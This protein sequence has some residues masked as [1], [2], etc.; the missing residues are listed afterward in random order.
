ML[1]EGFLL[2]SRSSIARRLA[3][4]APLARS[5]ARRFV[6]GDTI[7]D[8]VDATRLLNRQG[9]K[10]TIDYLGES[11]HSREEAR[12]AA[13]V[14]IDVLDRISAARLD[15]N[16]S[17]KLTQ[18]GQDI[19]LTF[20]RA[21]VGRILD[22]ARELDIFV[23]FDMESSAYTQRTLDFFR[24]VW[25][26]GYTNVGVVIQS[27]LRRSE[28]DIAML[29]EL[30]ARVRL[31]KG[32]YAEPESV[33]FPDKEDVDANFI[34]LMRHLLAHGNYPAIATHDERMIRATR[35][36]AEDR[37]IDPAAF[38]FQMLYG[39]RRD[40]QQQLVEDGYNV[41]VYVPFGGAWYPYLMR[42]LAERPANVLFV[43]DA[44]VRESP[45]GRILFDGSG[46]RDSSANG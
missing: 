45:L 6:A 26:E 14:Y 18:M 42:R 15:A 3:T 32:A 39:V 36:F 30:G 22:R 41:R 29:T 35:A 38:E 21:N 11:V 33:A 19:G 20:L 43:A 46:H 24:Y 37:G 7:D 4:H 13:D 9:L 23:R 5:M 1:K 16:I 31:C 10:V 28:A 40:V 25:D 34:R 12:A 27:Y 44:M 8:V 17:L 2:L